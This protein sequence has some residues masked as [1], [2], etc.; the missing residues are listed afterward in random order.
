MEV[1]MEESLRDTRVAMHVNVWS[2]LSNC[3]DVLLGNRYQP[4]YV[5]QRVIPEVW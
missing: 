2:V 3:G 1:C 4:F 5:G